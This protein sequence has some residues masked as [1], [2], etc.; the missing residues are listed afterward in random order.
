MDRRQATDHALAG[1][2][3][4]EVS[5]FVAA[6]L[7]GATLAALGADVIRVDPPGGGIDIDRWPLHGDLSLYRAG[8]NQGKRLIELDLRQKEDQ[9]KLGKLLAESGP[10]GGILLTNLPVVEWNSYEHLVRYRNDL[11]MLVITGNR[12]G[13]PA[14]DYT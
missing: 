12:D 13:T 10:N 2:R 1:L 7:A 8:L 14:V 9:E 6:P 3:V 5:A 4:V 11:I